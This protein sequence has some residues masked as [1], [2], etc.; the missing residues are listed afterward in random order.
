MKIIVVDDE[1]AALNTFLPNVID[2]P[3]VEC[4][5]FMNDPTAA[6]DYA[7]A[8]A[9]D[10]AFLDINMPQIGGVEL[11]ERLIALRPRM[12]I[13]FISGYLEDEAALRQKFGENLAG[14]CCKPYDS[15]QLRRMIASLSAAGPHLRLKMFDA[16]D[17]FSDGRAVRFSSS[18]SKELLALL[19][20]ANGSYVSMETAIDALWENKNAELGKRLY[21]DAVCRL[22]LTLKEVGAEKLVTFGRGCAVIDTTAAECDYWEFL[23]GVGVFSGKYLPQYGWSLPRELTLETMKPRF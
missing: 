11:A 7:E 23:R 21:R 3:K 17:L 14:C 4:K 19:A 2:S 10:A 5:M 13:V 18:K 8:E 1:L 22:R 9:V 15:E 16:F 6:L 20:D 12:K